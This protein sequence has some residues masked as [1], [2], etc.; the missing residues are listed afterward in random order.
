MWQC[1][2]V[3]KKKKVHFRP[4]SVA[5]PLGNFSNDNGDGNENNYAYFVGK[6]KLSTPCTCVFHFCPF[7]CRRLLKNNVKWPNLRFYE[8]RQHL[9]INSH[10]SAV[11]TSVIFEELP[12]PRQ[13][14]RL[15]KARSDCNNANVYCETTFPLPSSL[16]KFPSIP[17]TAPIKPYL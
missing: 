6:K 5:S 10:L 14:K 4:L 16:V 12:N 11:P 13:I 1:Q 9:R 8:G 2:E 17:D 3:L 15:K 7:I